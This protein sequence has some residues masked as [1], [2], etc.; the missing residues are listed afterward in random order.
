MS[1]KRHITIEDLRSNPMNCC[2]AAACE[3]ER[4]EARCTEWAEAYKS[5]DK[6]RDEFMNKWAEEKTSR[7]KAEEELK[8]LRS[9]IGVE[10]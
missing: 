4:L 9:R 2:L 7:L 6:G 5:A 8:N 3:I 1:D 10:G